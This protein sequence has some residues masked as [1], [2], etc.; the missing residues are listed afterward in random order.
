MCTILMRAVAVSLDPCY[1][2]SCILK[3]LIML[4]LFY[5]C[6]LMV[7]LALLWWSG[8]K[9]VTAIQSIALLYNLTSFFLGFLLLSVSTG[10]PELA[11]VIQSLWNNVPGLSV[12]D[13]IGSNFFVMTIVLGVSALVRPVLI[14][15]EDYL[16]TLLMIFLNLLVMGTLFS[17]ALF[18]RTYG[19]LLIAL[20]IVTILLLWLFRKKRAVR[21]VNN[22]APS[23]QPYE[24]V[25]PSKRL[26]FMHACIGISLLLISSKICAVAAIKIVA[27]TPLSYELIGATIIAIGTSLPE[28]ALNIIAMKRG[29]YALAFGNILGSIFEQG[30]LLFGI[31][32]FFSK[33]PLSTVNM[34]WLAPFFYGATGLVLADIF[35][36]KKIGRVA[37]ILLCLLWVSSIIY[38][39]SGFI[40]S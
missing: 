19:L 4:I 8:E 7:G 16:R 31:L 26:A 36:F 40:F 34:S 39:Y 17:I 1:W 25:Y 12:G 35:I 32:A 9:T 18:T 33:S 27:A 14:A 21:P 2:A 15:S 28:I 3:V 6:V 37:G 5:C 38:T 10:L 24:L 23:E 30:A 13:L 20:Y 22:G 11:I 29:D